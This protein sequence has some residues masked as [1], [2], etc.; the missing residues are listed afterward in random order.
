MISYKVLEEIQQYLSENNAADRI[1]VR[2][3]GENTVYGYNQNNDF[4]IPNFLNPNAASNLHTEETDKYAL[5]IPSFMQESVF[6]ELEYEI[7][8]DFSN[9]QG[10]PEQYIISVTPVNEDFATMLLRLIDEKGITDAECYKLAGI[11]RQH[12]NKIK[13][14]PGYKVKRTTALALCFALE[15]P[16]RDFLGLLSKAGFTLSNGSRFDLIVKYCLEHEIYN[17][18]D[19]NVILNSFEEPI[20][21]SKL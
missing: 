5:E 18:D 9:E 13:N 10:D 7:E 11:T 3:N 19:I 12:F 20:L 21:G 14:E 2:V 8:A 4:G 1:P 6:E 17:V 16:K 15:L